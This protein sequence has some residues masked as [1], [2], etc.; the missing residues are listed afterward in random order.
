[1]FTDSDR[2]DFIERM[3]K[4]GDGVEFD[5]NSC[6]G[7]DN[8][9]DDGIPSYHFFSCMSQWVEGNSAREMIDQAMLIEKV[10]G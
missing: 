4:S 1:M 9:G 3:L 6:L 10:N 8:E 2:M 5:Q 7:E